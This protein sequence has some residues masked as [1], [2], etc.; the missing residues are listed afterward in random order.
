MLDVEHRV[1]D[2]EPDGRLVET[3]DGSTTRLA[4][5]VDARRVIELVLSLVGADV[6]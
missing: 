6:G 5:G 4:V 2:V 3:D 1:L